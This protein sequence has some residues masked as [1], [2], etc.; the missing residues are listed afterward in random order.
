MVENAGIWGLQTTLNQGSFTSTDQLHGSRTTNAKGLLFKR[1]I[2]SQLPL[3]S[4]FVFIAEIHMLRIFWDQ[5]LWLSVP[6]VVDVIWPFHSMPLMW[7][8]QT[9]MKPCDS[10]QYSNSL[11]SH[12]KKQKQCAIDL[13]TECLLWNR[14]SISQK[15]LRIGDNRLKQ[16][17][18]QV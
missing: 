8:K 6:C 3:S 12:Q 11:W 14:A 10:A 15:L 17:T 18:R 2:K 7:L 4:L 1:L 9:L 5:G 13:K 16:G